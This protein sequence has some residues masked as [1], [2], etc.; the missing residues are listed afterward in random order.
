MGLFNN[1]KEINLLKEKI[2]DL[3]NQIW[4]IE[5]KIFLDKYK[6]IIEKLIENDLAVIH[7]HYFWV[8]KENDMYRKQLKKHNASNSELKKIEGLVIKFLYNE[9]ITEQEFLK[10]I[11]YIRFHIVDYFYKKKIDLEQIIKKIK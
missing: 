4:K 11:M 2:N 6:H 3:T 1:K 10:C 9:K 5:N 7:N 8:D